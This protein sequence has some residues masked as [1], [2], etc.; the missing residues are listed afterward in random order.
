MK[1]EDYS[2]YTRCNPQGGYSLR[3]GLLQAEHPY[4]QPNEMLKVQSTHEH[5]HRSD[6]F[7]DDLGVI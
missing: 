6:K 4:L 7:N 2:D 5:E 3:W 1:P